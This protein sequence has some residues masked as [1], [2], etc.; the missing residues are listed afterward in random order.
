MLFIESIENNVYVSPI[1]SNV[2]PDEWDKNH[3]IVPIER[4]GMSTEAQMNIVYNI[5]IAGGAEVTRLN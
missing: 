4:R 2:D 3:F 1:N 5:L